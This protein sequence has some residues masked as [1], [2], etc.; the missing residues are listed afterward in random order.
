[1]TAVVYKIQGGDY[2]H[3][4]TASR[5]LKEQLKQVGADPAVVRRAMIA[6]YEA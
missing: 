5:A 3:G 4:G 1:M 6:A 2:E